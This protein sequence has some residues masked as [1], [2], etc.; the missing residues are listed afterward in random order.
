L[1]SLHTLCS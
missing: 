1:T